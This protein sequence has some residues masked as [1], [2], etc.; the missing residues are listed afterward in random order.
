M[1]SAS[2]MVMWFAAALIVLGVVAYA[3]MIYNGLVRLRR[4]VDKAWSNI[5]VLLKQR[6]SELDNL[7]DTTEEYMEYEEEVLQKITE[8]RAQVQEA[9]SPKQE[10][11][12]DEA[13][14]GAL[15]DISATA[16]DYPKLRSSE[17]FQQLM[18]RIS[19]LEEQ[20]ADRREFYNESVNRYNIRIEQIPYVFVAKALDYEEKELFEASPEAKQNVD[21]GAAFGN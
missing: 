12:A 5:D 14:K 8:A 21:V 3:V 15:A 9:E 13:L 6:S 17:N 19:S 18:E 7:I 11:E 1:V 10:A 20:I 4:N 2:E 16:E